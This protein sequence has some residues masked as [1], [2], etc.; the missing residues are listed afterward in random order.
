MSFKLFAGPVCHDK[1]AYLRFA[2]IPKHMNKPVRNQSIIVLI[3]LLMLPGLAFSS[4]VFERGVSPELSCS[5]GVTG[6]FIVKIRLGEYAIDASGKIQLAEKWKKYRIEQGGET[7]L[8]FDLA[9]DN[10][11]DYRAEISSG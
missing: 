7:L 1:T 6:D 4:Q 8:A 5:K 3:L 9:I 10:T 11:G 2:E